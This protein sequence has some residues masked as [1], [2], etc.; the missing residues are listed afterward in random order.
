MNMVAVN[1]VAVNTEAQERDLQKVLAFHKKE[2]PGIYIAVVMVHMALETLGEVK[3][4]LNAV[5]ETEWCLPDAIQVLTGCTT[6]NRQ[7]QIAPDLGRYALTLFDRDSGRGCRVSV[8]LKSIQEKQYPELF[9]FFT[10]TRDP[11]LSNDSKARKLSGKKIVEEFSR[12]GRSILLCEPVQIRNPGKPPIPPAVICPKCGESFLIESVSRKECTVCEG[13]G[14][15]LP[16]KK[17]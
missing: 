14:Y 9:R 17:L 5:A 16:S 10:R 6:G 1:M 2:A 13:N 12:A 15:Y 7:M 11:K 8:Q 3:S 4:S